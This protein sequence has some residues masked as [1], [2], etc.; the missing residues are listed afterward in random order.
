M[1]LPVEVVAQRPEE[2]IE[3]G[4]LVSQVLG[5]GDRLLECLGLL[6]GDG[7]GLLLKRILL[8]QNVDGRVDRVDLLEQIGGA[9]LLKGQVL[10]L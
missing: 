2:V 3:V 7:A 1:W 6:V 4:D 5:R 10:D 8:P 9:G